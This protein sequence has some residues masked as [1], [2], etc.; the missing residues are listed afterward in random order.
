MSHGSLYG[1]PAERLAQLTGSHIATARR[2]K[3]SSRAPRWLLRLV[4]ICFEGEL[5]EIDASW[6]GWRLV[7]GELFSPE[8]VGFTPGAVRAGPLFRARADELARQIKALTTTVDCDEDR[9]RRLEKL[10]TLQAMLY[11]ASRTF[12][13]LTRELTDHEQKRLF[14]S[15]PATRERVTRAGLSAYIGPALESTTHGTRTR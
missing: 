2:W 4:A 12:E 5:G 1:Y 6:Q 14:E 8:D 7:R 13:E 3:R 15:H 11:T 10:A 9:R